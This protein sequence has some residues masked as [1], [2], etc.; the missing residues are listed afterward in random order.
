MQGGVQRA[1]LARFAH[2]LK[3]TKGGRGS[4]EKK[5]E[6]PAATTLCV[7]CVAC[8]FFFSEPASPFGLSRTV[9]AVQAVPRA[10]AQSASPRH[11]SGSA[12]DQ[13]FARALDLHHIE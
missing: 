11:L 13:N 6:G 4:E 12:S 8:V 10:R 3:S 5:K 1:R 2:V 9:Q 7:L